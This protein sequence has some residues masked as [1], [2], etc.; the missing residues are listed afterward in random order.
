MAHE[1]EALSE[2]YVRK[3]GQNLHID[4]SR[5]PSAPA[6][7]R[8]QPSETV[9]LPFEFGAKVQI[10]GDGSIVGAV[11]GFCFYPNRLQIEVAWFAN[12]DAKSA[13]FDIFRVTAK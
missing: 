7:F 8:R 4:I 13:W 9:D 6:A 11:T 12:G 2:G 3:G 5:R 10:D 1:I